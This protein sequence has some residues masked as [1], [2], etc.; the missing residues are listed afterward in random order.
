MVRQEEEARRHYVCHICLTT[1]VNFGYS[2]PR[3]GW[4]GLYTGDTDRCSPGSWQQIGNL[5]LYGTQENPA[6]IDLACLECC[7]TQ[8]RSV[9][10]ADPS[11]IPTPSHFDNFEFS[12]APKLVLGALDVAQR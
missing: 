9:A 11:H 7:V 8:L 2:I 1:P 10:R 5:N 3:P 4:S 12:S 6:T